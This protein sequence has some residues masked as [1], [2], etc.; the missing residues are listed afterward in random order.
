MAA[1][2]GLASP[3][4]FLAACGGD[5]NDGGSAGTQKPAGLVSEPS[6]TTKNATKGGVLSV[7]STDPPNSFDFTAG[8]GAPDY[9]VH[10]YSRL[11]KYE[12]LKYPEPAVSAV[13]PDA[14]TSWETS[15]DGLTYTYKLR[16]GMK[17]DSRPPTNGRELTAQ[18]VIFSWDRF[19]KL[20]SFRST[21]V[22]SDRSGGAS[23][24]GY[25]TRRLHSCR[26]ACVSLRAVQHQLWL[27]PVWPDHARGVRRWRIRPEV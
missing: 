18:D 25:C 7:S 11:M 16:R 1:V 6:D 14:A 9:S 20:S 2:G 8:S 15:P 24:F 19:A 21:M 17:F 22:N 26:E 13:V 5:D 27:L 4:R 3:P 10:V 12:V 23:C